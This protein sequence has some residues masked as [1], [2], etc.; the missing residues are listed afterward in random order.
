MKNGTIIKTVSTLCAGALALTLS[1][2]SSKNNEI[3]T[4]TGKE[5]VLRKLDDKV[6]GVNFEY[7]FVDENNN[8]ISID[9]LEINA[10]EGKDVYAKSTSKNID[11]WEVVAVYDTEIE[12]YYFDVEEVE[13]EI[14]KKTREII[15]KIEQEEPIPTETPESTKTPKPEKTKEPKKTAKPTKSPKPTP[16]PTINQ[17]PNWSNPNPTKK[18]WHHHHEPNH[19]TRPIENKK[20]YLFLKKPE[21]KMPEF[22]NSVFYW[23][24][25]NGNKRL[26]Y[27]EI[28]VHSYYAPN[29]TDSDTH[30]N[31]PLVYAI[32]ENKDKYLRQGVDS[33]WQYV[34]ECDNSSR[35][36]YPTIEIADEYILQLQRNM[37]FN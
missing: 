17:W 8:G 9:E 24:D 15:S 20:L 13:R 21:T 16:V 28:R 12:K 7:S 23:V 33:R 3:S 4:S 18:P 34:G 1:G 36:L 11:G 27:Q 26:E 22:I 31:Y 30:I 35:D 6:N 25:D 37:K 32:T 10:G 29:A 5:Y 14:N 2:C 19:T